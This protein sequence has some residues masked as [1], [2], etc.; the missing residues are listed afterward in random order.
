MSFVLR[1]K[2]QPSPQAV[3]GIGVPT[4]F[5][6]SG[7][8]LRAFH[9]SWYNFI[10]PASPGYEGQINAVD[11][12]V[13]SNTWSIV[14]G[15]GGGSG[16]GEAW[17]EGASEFKISKNGVT[18]A[19]DF[20]Y[21]SPNAFQYNGITASTVSGNR[22]IW[23]F[24]PAD[25]ANPLYVDG[26]TI[27]TNHNKPS[28]AGLQ[29]Y[30]PKKIRFSDNNNRIFVHF[31]SFNNTIEINPEVESGDK[32]KL[33]F[34]FGGI[35][36]NNLQNFEVSGDGNHIFVFVGGSLKL[37]SWD[38][39]TWQFSH[40]FTNSGPSCS[41]NFDGS[42]IAIQNSGVK[43]YKKTGGI[44]AQLGGDLPDGTPWVNSAGILV[45]TGTSLYKWNGTSWVFQWTT[46][47]ALSDNG[48]AAITAAGAG[49]IQR[50]EL[51]DLPPIYK[52]S[53]IASS[54]YAGSVIANSAY[55]GSQ[56]IWPT[57][58]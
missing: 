10:F 2:G 29:H 46:L 53:T 1:Q 9:R 52:G 44:W 21:R 25:P 47:G 17:D 30:E 37:F 39:S 4:R 18:V 8:G 7:D 38:G 26:T 42:I 5:I 11:W 49:S 57:N 13:I 58:L 27:T 55:Y 54:I 19:W 31:T 16:G 33:W 20:I 56:K 24:V 51:E 41:V 28:G 6:L 15:M 48:E 34:P 22:N 12:N 50:Y 23:A 14:A 3:P 36:G 40:E 32:S 43:V 35:Y 45:N